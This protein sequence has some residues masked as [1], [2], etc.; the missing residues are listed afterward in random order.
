M[1][2]KKTNPT[3]TARC[4]I[5][6][7]RYQKDGFGIYVVEPINT[8]G[9]EVDSKGQTVISGGT[10]PLVPELEYIISAKLT[11]HPKY[12][13]QYKVVS[14][15]RES[16]GVEGAE[17]FL[18]SIISHNHAR[19]LLEVYPNIIQM[20]MN[21]E[22]I[23]YSLTKGI[24][25]STFDKIRNKVFEN[26]AYLDMLNTY[27]AIFTK[28]LIE[29]MTEQNS[30]SQIKARLSDDPY[31]F[32]MSFKGIGFKKADGLVL[33]L[34]DKGKVNTKE[35][36]R[37]SLERMYKAINY[38][39]EQNEGTGNTCMTIKELREEA[40][41]LTPECIDKF[42]TCI[43]E[44]DTEIYVDLDN[45]LVGLKATRD[46]ELY[47]YNKL[48]KMMNGR[49][50]WEIVDLDMYKCINGMELTD[51]QR[52]T[53]NI[54]NESNV[55][56]LVGAGGTG[57]S[58]SMMSVVKA[59]E[60]N[61]IKYHLCSPTG[62]ASKVMSNYTGRTAKTIHRL[63][64]YGEPKTLESDRTTHFAYNE[65]HKLFS[66]LIIIDEAG[67]CDVDLMYNLLLA[68][69]ERFTKLLIVGDDGQLPSVG[70]G[71]VLHDLIH[72]KIVPVNRL[73][74]VFRYAEG[75]L[76]QVCEDARNGK[77]YLDQIPTNKVKVFGNNKDFVHMEKYDTTSTLKCIED[78]FKNL[79]EKHPIEDIIV[80]TSQNKGDLGTININKQLQKIYHKDK[81]D[82]N[83]MFY[84][85]IEF[86]E[87]DK[88]IQNT[89]NYKAETING[90]EVGVF[91]GNTGTIVRID[92]TDVYIDFDGD[93]I[94]YD[95][96][97][98]GQ[99]NLAYSISVFKAQG[100]Q[101]KQVLL[102]LPRA[103]TF[104][105]NSNLIYT[106]MSRTSGRCIT[107]GNLYTINR[108]LKK[109]ANLSRNTWL[110]TFSKD[111]NKEV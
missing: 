45:K 31:N 101:C 67:M 96:K 1:A 85:E 3:I 68:I 75:G 51:E 41:K 37:N 6:S 74:K 76:A 66:N 7:C 12:G 36:L 42:P 60:N 64:E 87:G 73:T 90:G 9:M 19:T 25:E 40:E 97:E 70:A 17:E 59:C 52:N 27:G 53:L 46:K 20:I 89:N 81:K 78:G 69:N 21:N 77:G 23:D 34:E 47:I 24:G 99:V 30:V 11:V 83:S 57:K 38:I 2:T 71:N 111:G 107:I 106:G 33:A 84:G 18:C 98:M 49:N 48:T 65:D 39:L 44:H 95:K 103:H 32:L 14:I 94:K 91:N 54:I 72:S 79:L 58:A 82:E 104:M 4:K 8:K 13:K 108:A 63:L 5:I 105:L 110:I 22:P 50:A 28:S 15:T 109:R 26:Y 92:D 102:V 10:D 35:P 86:I 16:K 62:K 93:I 80:I 100:S 56:V 88:V 43:K 29:K 61:K 55:G